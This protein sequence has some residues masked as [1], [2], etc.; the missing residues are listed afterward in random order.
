MSEVEIGKFSDL[1]ELVLFHGHY[2]YSR[3]S[4]TVLLFLYKNLI[5]TVILFAY[6]FL[7]D[8]SGSSIFNASLLVGYNIFF[9]TPPVL[10]LGV[11]DEDASKRAL[12]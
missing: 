11:L 6:I 10:V 2:N 5:L 3:M 8:Y 1:L 12:M 7:S 4:R 9:T